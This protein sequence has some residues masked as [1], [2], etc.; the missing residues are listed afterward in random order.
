MSRTAWRRRA[1]YEN[2]IKENQHEPTEEGAQDIIHECLKGSQGVAQPKW[3]HQELVEAVVCAER[4]LVDVGRIHA[5]L[6]IP[7]AQVKLGEEPGAVE[8]VQELIDHWYGKSVLH[9]DGVQ[10][11]VIH[12]EAPRAVGLLDEEDRR[13][14]CGGTPADQALGEHG[15]ALPL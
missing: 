4:R 7:R 9:S 11:A 3:H 8:F 15:G 2:I 6:M 10:G 14:E 12:T 1:V 5:D 13:G